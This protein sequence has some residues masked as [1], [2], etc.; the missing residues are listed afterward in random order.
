[1]TVKE[2]Q[3]KYSFEILSLPHPEREV[4]GGYI[5]DLL[6]W[7]MGRA[8]EDNAWITIMTNVNIAAVAALADVSVVI[9][10]E[11]AKPDLSVVETAEAKGV[12]ILSSTQTAYE[13]A[14]RICNDI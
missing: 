10:A 6:S 4:S 8:G 7:V 3:E 13:L 2:L 14:V 11:G 1:M 12:N 5:G 9:I